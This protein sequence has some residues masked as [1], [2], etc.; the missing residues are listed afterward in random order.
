MAAA[1]SVAPWDRDSL[2]AESSSEP[3]ATLSVAPRT[4]ATTPR[5]RATMS[6]RARASTP[7]SSFWSISNCSVKSPS[8]MRLANSTPSMT[9]RVM[10]RVRSVAT[11]VCARRRSS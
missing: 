7:I 3:E 9:G 10:L 11:V 6:L 2:E 8:A 1:C 4:S 5:R